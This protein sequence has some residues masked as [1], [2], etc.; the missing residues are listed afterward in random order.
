MRCTRSNAKT[1]PCCYYCCEESSVFSITI[2]PCPLSDGI[3]PSRKTRTN[4]TGKSAVCGTRG[5]RKSL[6]TYP[7]LHKVEFW[8]FRALY[9]LRRLETTLVLLIT[10]ATLLEQSYVSWWDISSKV[11][12][13]PSFWGMFLMF[14]T[15]Q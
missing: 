14:D 2:K 10:M 7:Q 5:L 4:E 8:C 9:K 6:G 15:P 3:L 1:T 12:E 11:N 13:V